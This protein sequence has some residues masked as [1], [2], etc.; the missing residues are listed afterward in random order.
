MRTITKR[1]TCINRGDYAKNWE[2]I[3]KIEA[4]YLAKMTARGWKVDPSYRC[5]GN[6]M[7]K[8]ELIIR[9]TKNK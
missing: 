2:A 1:L 4:S 5:A 6:A 8:F 9:L 7:F 3:S